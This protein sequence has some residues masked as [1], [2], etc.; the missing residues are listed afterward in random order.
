MPTTLIIIF[1][2]LFIAIFFGVW[3][4]RDWSNPDRHSQIQTVL[5]IIGLTIAFVALIPF[6][7][8][9][10][11][12]DGS[13]IDIQDGD[14]NPIPTLE[15]QTIEAVVSKDGESDRDEIEAS[16]DSSSYN[17]TIEAT[18][19]EPLEPTIINTPISTPTN[20]PDPTPM[21]IVNGHEW[22]LIPAGEFLMGPIENDTNAY[23][24]E[25]PNFWFEINY[26]YWIAINE[27]T[28]SQYKKF[29]D[30]GNYQHLP[31]CIWN[32]DGTYPPRLDNDPVVCVSFENAIAYT[33]WLSDV[34][35]HTIMLPNEPEWEKAAGWNPTSQQKQ[36]YP[37]GNMFDG[38]RLN[39][40]DVNCGASY[41][42]PNIDNQFTSTSPVGYFENGVSPYGLLDTA[43]N[44]W[45]W[46]RSKWGSS[47]FD[48]PD[49]GYPYNPNDGR[50]EIVLD[51]M[52]RYVTRG[53]SWDN[54]LK[55]TRVSHR[56]PGPLL[57]DKEFKNTGFRVVWIP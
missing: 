48:Y 50:E 3:A 19:V 31:R 44:A 52:T 49:Y 22:V 8:V 29:I 41:A 15:N 54:S 32:E 24:S 40:C 17:I 30:D 51:G 35:G 55:R 9:L 45:E 23:S 11:I 42:D 2:S 43:G 28:N 10:F 27:T 21:P 46:T 14:E 7:Q 4:W 36:I 26:D 6:D 56:F 5:A 57:V 34:T 13:S 1:L 53:G 33:N 16:P 38:T 18:R 12:D 39:Y 25:I 37:W 47:S 20:V